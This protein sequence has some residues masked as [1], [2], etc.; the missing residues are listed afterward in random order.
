MLIEVGQRNVLSWRLERAVMT[1]GYGYCS[2]CSQYRRCAYVYGQDCKY[3]YIKTFSKILLIINSVKY[4]T[5]VECIYKFDHNILYAEHNRHICTSILIL[6][7]FGLHIY[8]NTDTSIT[9]FLCNN[10]AHTF[11]CSK[12]LISH[13]VEETIGW[14]SDTNIPSWLTMVYCNN[15]DSMS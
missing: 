2:N 5:C 3:N 12:Q 7:I 10:N 15:V 4:K 14:T 1:L 11:R 13:F 8:A 9:S 6:I